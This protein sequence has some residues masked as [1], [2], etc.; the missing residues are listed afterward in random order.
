MHTVV[1]AGF[2]ADS[3]AGRIDNAGVE[4]HAVRTVVHSGSYSVC[5]LYRHIFL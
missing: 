5:F 1:F 2:G 3:L 4:W